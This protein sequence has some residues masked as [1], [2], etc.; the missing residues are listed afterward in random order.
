MI[1]VS[2]LRRPAMAL[3]LF[4]MQTCGPEIFIGDLNSLLRKIN[5]FQDV[6]TL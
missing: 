6:R 4:I 2:S 3:C 5:M 1:V